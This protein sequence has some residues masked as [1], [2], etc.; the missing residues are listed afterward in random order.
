MLPG[1]L[2]L[3]HL[4]S[5]SLFLLPYL[6]HL[7]NQQLKEHVQ[8]HSVSRHI[9]IVCVL[10]GKTSFSRHSTLAAVKELSDACTCTTNTRTHT[11]RRQRLRRGEKRTRGGGERLNRNACSLLVSKESLPRKHNFLGNYTETILK[12]PLI[13]AQ[14][15]MA[16]DSFIMYIRQ[17]LAAVLTMVCTVHVIWVL[18]SSLEGSEHT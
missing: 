5:P 12:W 1:S 15:H 10:F 14:C 3:P 8:T 17:T 6:F 2:S 4:A 9:D 16:K 7:F 11:H 13:D 18:V